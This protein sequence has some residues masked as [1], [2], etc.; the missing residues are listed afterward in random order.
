M[1]EVKDTGSIQIESVVQFMS[2][3]GYT[4]NE[5]TNR[6]ETD[7]FEL[8]HIRN[9]KTTTAISLHNLQEYGY[10][11]VKAGFFQPKLNGK[12][13]DLLMDGYT[14]QKLLA[15]KVVKR[16]KLQVNNKGEVKVHSNNVKV[17][18]RPLI[19]LLGLEA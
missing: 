2:Y 1:F 3:I 12:L 6:F 13:F 17:Q 5:T 8:R 19:R 10:E 14:L 11:E 18:S 15:T 4:F 9:L 7:K 16:A